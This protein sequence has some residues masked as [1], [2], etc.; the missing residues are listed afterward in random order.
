M[1]QRVGLEGALESPANNNLSNSTLL[2]QQMWKRKPGVG[3]PISPKTLP[4][5]KSLA[6]GK[7]NK[8]LKGKQLAA[9]E[10]KS[11]WKGHPYQFSTF[12]ISFRCLEQTNIYAIMSI[13]QQTIC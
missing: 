9:D 5:E 2:V 10:G 11:S 3:H 13:V 1:C 7:V 8:R 4:Q 6:S 12:H